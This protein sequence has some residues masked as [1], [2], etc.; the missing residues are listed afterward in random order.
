MF[1]W[2]KILD[3][4][5]MIR[6]FRTSYRPRKN[7]PGGKVC[8]LWLENTVLKDA[9]LR[10][11]DGIVV[12]FIKEYVHI[13]TAKPFEMATYKLHSKKGEPILDICNRDIHSIL[14]V[15]V[16]IDVVVK[17]EELYVY[18]EETFNLV[19]MGKKPNYSSDGLSKLRVM[20]LFCGGGGMTSAFVNTQAF[21]SVF[22]V[23]IDEPE[24]NPY[25]YE[26][27]GKTPGYRAWAIETF[28]NN[29]PQ[30][31]LYWGDVRSVNPNYVPACDVALVS[32]PCVEY[33]GLGRKQNGVVE[34]FTFHIV[35]IILE[36]GARAVFIENVPDYFK[37]DSYEKL[38]SML[39]DVFPEWHQQNINSYDLGS[40]NMRKRGYAVAFKQSTDFEFPKIPKIPEN[41][42][43]KVSDYIS[44][45]KN[46]EWRST[47]EGTMAYYLSPA[48]NKKYEHTGFT[49][50]NNPL[51]LL[52]PDSKKVSCFT[53]G[54]ANV[55]PHQ[56][57]LK[58][59][60]DNTLW[61][62]F[63]PEEVQN[64][65]EYPSWFEFPEDMSNTRKYQILGNS[66]NCMA[67]EAIASNIIST[68]MKLDIRNLFKPK[69]KKKEKLEEQQLSFAF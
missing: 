40:I 43:K 53:K 22:A 3:G 56:S 54:Y 49:M 25:D 24:K 20:S 13:R 9:G 29:F 57:Y 31:L 69:R 61:D 19:S 46:R 66:V 48:R 47:T 14:G 33:S 21:E 35:R 26:K 67:I 5:K 7:D 44:S 36:S 51:F 39:A 59:P 41:R 64:M 11:G 63:T 16:K 38:K 60:T 45:I 55:Q 18:K 58:H 52:K 10:A 30:T 27:Q 1:D 65:L 28:R 12:N 37:S 4:A 42:R 34:H 2:K 68:L 62:K 6:N 17:D 8:R 50:D 32:P 23:D 15:N